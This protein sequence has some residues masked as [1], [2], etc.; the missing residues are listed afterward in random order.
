MKKLLVLMVAAV[1]LASGFAAPASA[2]IQVSGDAYAGI[3]TNYVW[4][5]MNLSPDANFVVQPGTDLSAKGFT[6]GWWGNFDENSGNLNEVD[7][8]LDYSFDPVKLVS[9]SVGNILYDVD[10]AKDT[11][12]LYLGATLNTLLSPSFK[13]Y[14]DYDEA[15]KAGLFYTLSVS[16]SLDLAKGLALNLGALGSYNQRSDYA[17]GDYTG[18]HNAELTASVDYA[19]TDQLTVTPS[20]LFSMPLS[21][22]GDKALVPLENQYVGGLNV[23]YSF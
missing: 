3:F 8:T 20:F 1:T 12:E 17:V 15:Q 2:A 18:F 19:V 23:A 5:G 22:N 14:Y 21:N 13:V 11:N 16:H 6:L 7:L 4:R 9:V 10:G